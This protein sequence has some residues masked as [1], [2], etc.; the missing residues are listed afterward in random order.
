MMNVRLGRWKMICQP[1]RREALD[2][3]R[4]NAVLEIS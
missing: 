1:E 3:S 2:R 4:M